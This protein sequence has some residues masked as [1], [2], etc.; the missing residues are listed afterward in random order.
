LN[1]STLLARVTGLG[2]A[3]ALLASCGGGGGSG[4]AVSG[5]PAP[6]PVPGAPAGCVVHIVAD[7]GVEAGKTAGAAA[8]ACTGMLA[9]V[10]WTQVSGPTVTLLAARS[11]TV[12]FETAATGT[13]RLRAD[14]RMADGSAA[15]ATTDIAVSAQPAGSTITVR[16]DHAAR[17]D[18]DTS[19]RAWPTLVAG[20]S[21]RDIVWTQVSGPAVTMDTTNNRLLMFKTP[22]VTADTVL[23]FRATMTTSSG[24]QDYDDV[25][26]GVDAQ[27]AKPN[28][29][30]F[31][32]TERVHPYRPASQYAGVLTRCAYDNSLYYLSSSNTNL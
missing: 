14:V 5:T 26:I 13:V 19:V 7:S 17:P 28:G 6:I 23:K 30:L 10:T 31:A 18:T 20:E 16:A 15:S 3:G 25:L 2:L 24:R 9:D 22:N 8:Q 32:S 27:A 29:Y 11:S 12:A 21:L 4:G 1:L